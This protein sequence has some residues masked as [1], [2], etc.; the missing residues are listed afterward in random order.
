MNPLIKKLAGQ[1]AVYGLSSIVG[2]LL[3]YL[4]VP[5]YTRLFLPDEYGVIT[6]IYSYTGIAI[7]ML[8]YGLETG[9]FRFATNN[10]DESSLYQS[11]LTSLALSGLIF[12]SIIFVFQSSINTG[13][14]LPSDN[15]FVLIMALTVSFDAF[16]ALP[17]ARLRHLSKAFHF[18]SFKLFGILLNIGLNVLF[19]E[20]DLGEYLGL[21]TYFS[22]VGYV[23]LSNFVSTI[24]TLV[25][26]LSYIELFRKFD[27]KLLRTVL[28]YSYPILF[29]GLAG[30]VNESGDKILLKYILGYTGDFSDK[31][32][33][34]E[35]GIYGANFKIAIFMMLFIQA[36]RFAADPF[37]FKN[38][39]GANNKTL[40]ASV[41]H[42]FV[43]TGGLVFLGIIT[44]MHF[45]K[46]FISSS[47]HEGLAIVPILLV[48]KWVYGIVFSMSF[49]YKLTDRTIYGLYITL[50]GSA[51]TLIGSL[52]VIP[53]FG[54]VGLS[55]VILASYS[56]MAG[57]SYY[58]GQKYFPVPYNK[59]LIIVLVTVPIILYMLINYL[60]VNTLDFILPGIISM[61]AYVGFAYYINKNWNARKHE[62]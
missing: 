31:Q 44:F 19:Y 58:Y 38:S 15:Y 30:M 26:M 29:L 9:Y 23:F 36:F 22:G 51:V 24:L 45:I 43:F 17:F 48:A 11:L 53:Y 33:M 59:R 37:F 27:F 52:L 55:Y 20:T 6:E 4:L 50:V 2:R 57:L 35:L 40:Y 13:I 60:S 21:S 41:M 16:L 56:A 28:Q 25:A 47:Y 61:I 8:T 32:I 1:T 3:N 10:K 42:Y 39:G 18:A 5:Y 14:G 7:I 12:V 54:Y 46:G 34:H 62:S 49:W